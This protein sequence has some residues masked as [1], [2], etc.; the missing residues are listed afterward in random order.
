MKDLLWQRSQE[1]VLKLPW[2]G[3]KGSCDPTLEP[4]WFLLIRGTRGRSW[5]GIISR[6]PCGDGSPGSRASHTSENCGRGP[7]SALSTAHPCPPAL[8]QHRWAPLSGRIDGRLGLRR[9]GVASAKRGLQDLWVP[10]LPPSSLLARHIGGSPPA[11]PSPLVQ[12]GR[13][14]VMVGNGG[15]GDWHWVWNSS[16]RLD[17][18]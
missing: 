15:R 2:T 18:F 13:V 10:S 9:K 6:W 17:S 12:V 14:P 3:G 1:Q 5:A 11:P 4:L 7:L 8:R 16:F